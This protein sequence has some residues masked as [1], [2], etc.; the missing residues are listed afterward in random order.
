[1]NKFKEDLIFGTN[2]EDEIFE[3]LKTKYDDIERTSA[4]STFDYKTKSEKLKIE[5][6][7]R[8]NKSDAYPTTMIG[9]NKIKKCNDPDTTYLFIFKFTD[10]TLFIKYN[11]EI[12]NKFENKIG[13]RYDRKRSGELSNYIYIPITSLTPL[14]DL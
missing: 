12:F 13:G 3:I 2:A 9:L 8:R 11:V 4:Y 10:Q 1:M 7:T 6:K 14:E 5:L